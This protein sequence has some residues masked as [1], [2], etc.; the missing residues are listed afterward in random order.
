MTLARRLGLRTFAP[1]HAGNMAAAQRLGD[2]TWI[3][4]A[5]AELAEIHPD[6]GEKAW[7]TDM[8]SWNRVWQGADVG[9]RPRGM[10][11]RAERRKD[12]QAFVTG[13]QW[14]LEEAFAREDFAAAADA[15]RRFMKRDLGSPSA[16]LWAGRAA[17]HNGDVAGAQRALALIERESGRATMADTAMLRAGIAARQGRVDDALSEYRTALP[18]YRDLELRFD[19]ALTGLDMAALLGPDVPGVRAAAA[20]AR[21]I[22]VEL[23]ARPV[24]AR[25][26]RLVAAAAPAAAA[27]V[28]A[29]S[30]ATATSNAVVG[31]D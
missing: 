26:D 29:G 16:W 18:I 17:L 11:V 10:V 13:W 4:E 31:T 28:P 1:Y 6:P 23:G 7:I 2:W 14:V 27:P 8:G 12:P 15:G 19:I 30:A 3:A 20:E 25:L 22:L 9:D 24:I 5:A 21:A